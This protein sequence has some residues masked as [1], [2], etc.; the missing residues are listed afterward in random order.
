MKVTTDSCVF[1]AWV[2]ER[3]Q[4]DQP[5]PH[6]ILDIGTGT[7]LLALMIGQAFP[8]TPIQGVEIDALAVHQARENVAA[9]E[10]ETNVQV[11]PADIRNVSS[12]LPFDQIVSNPPFYEQD[13][14]GPDPLKNQAHHDATLPV[15]NLIGEIDRLL[16]D[17]GKFHLLLPAKG[18]EERIGLLKARGLHI[19]QQVGL[20]H[21]SEHPMMRVFI[22]GRREPAELVHF[23]RIFIHEAD[24]AYT[25]RMQELLKDYYLAF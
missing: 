8:N 4:Q 14:T 6:R 10:C 18:I 9:A 7:G 5:E 24:G 21:S 12:E 19:H 11:V 13:L 16:S 3:M 20:H 1:G 2:V 17:T 15:A 25:A 22:E 23:E